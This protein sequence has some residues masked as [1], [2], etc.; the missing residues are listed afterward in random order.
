MLLDDL[1]KMKKLING[2][3][4]SYGAKNLR[5]FGS[6]SR[7]EETQDSDIDLVAEFPYGYDLFSQRMPLARKLSELTGRKI[8]LVPEHEL[9][10]HIKDTIFK[11]AKKI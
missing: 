5:V 7:G 1:H 8:D 9:N 10:K 4:S 2:L 11:E 3:A 6:V